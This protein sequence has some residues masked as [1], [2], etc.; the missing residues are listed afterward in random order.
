MI[1]LAHPALRLSAIATTGFVASRNF[2]ECAQGSEEATVAALR[3]QQANHGAMELPLS[4]EDKERLAKYRADA[5]SKGTSNDAQV[6]ADPLPDA[7]VEASSKEASALLASSRYVNP[8]L[9][10]GTHIHQSQPF[11]C[12]IATLANAL[13]TETEF[14]AFMVM[15]RALP[16]FVFPDLVKFP[17]CAAIAAPEYDPTVSSLWVPSMLDVTNFAICVTASGAQSPPTAKVEFGFGAA[18]GVEES[19]L[20]AQA[21]F[22]RDLKLLRPGTTLALSFDRKV[23]RQ[24]GGGHWTPVCAYCEEA[25]MVLVM[26]TAR[27]YGYYWAPVSILCDAMRTR[28]MYGQSRGWVMVSR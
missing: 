17:R 8:E 1:R 21:R 20:E 13:R 2:A 14:Q 16:R 4:D 10:D 22:R 12:A 18:V 7:F 9:L 25:D 15:C 19:V 28:N 11:S 27:R 6:H 3:G 5:K 26:D 24:T 23:A